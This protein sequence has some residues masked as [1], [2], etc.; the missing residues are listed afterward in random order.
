MQTRGSYRVTLTASG[1]MFPV[2][3]GIARAAQNASRTIIPMRTSVVSGPPKN[4]ISFPEKVL[5]G[6]GIAV[7]MLG[8]PSYVLVNM[9]KYTASAE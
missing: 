8:I 6:A 1:K 9:K 4:R 5:A 3:S 2:S 7:A